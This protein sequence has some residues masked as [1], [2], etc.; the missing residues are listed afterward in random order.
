MKAEWFK[1]DRLVDGCL[2]LG[3]GRKAIFFH[4]FF[5]YFVSDCT[6]AVYF[7]VRGVTNRLGQPTLIGFFFLFEC[8]PPIQPSV[9]DIFIWC[10]LAVLLMLKRCCCW[11]WERDQ[12]WCGSRWL[13]SIFDEFECAKLS[14]IMCNCDTTVESVCASRMELWCFHINS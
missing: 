6:A 1:S 11:V 12:L 10:W 5:N 8:Q 3:Y 14:W 9:V 2:T 7:S 4:F 13:R